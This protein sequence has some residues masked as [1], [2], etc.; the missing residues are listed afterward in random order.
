MK[1]VLG[2]LAVLLIIGLA[3]MAC[4]NPLNGSGARSR[5]AVGGNAIVWNGAD[6]KAVAL[7]IGAAANDTRKNAS[8]PKISSNAH[9]ADF[10]VSTLFGITN[11]GTAVI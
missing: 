9:N 8:G 7:E 4:T 3:V 10:P 11:R 2:G 5:A 6:D 1:K